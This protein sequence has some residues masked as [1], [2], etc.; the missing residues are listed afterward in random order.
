MVA[1]IFVA[2]KLFGGNSSKEQLEF[3]LT[4][5]NN[6]GVDIYR[7]YASETNTDN[8]EEDILGDDILYAGEQFLIVFTIT[9]DNMDWDFA[10]E[11]SQGNMLEFYDLSFADCDV[12]GAT[13]VL[14]YDGEEATA[15]LY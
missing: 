11:D 12:D 10:I 3:N 6:T 7:L 14:D 8:W 15:S 2:V 9:E 13:L 5:V 1:I 4:V